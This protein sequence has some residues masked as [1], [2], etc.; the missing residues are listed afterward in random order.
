[1]RWLQARVRVRARARVRVKVGVRVRGRRA[2]VRVKAWIRVKVGVSGAGGAGAVQGLVRG[3]VRGLRHLSLVGVHAARDGRARDDE[4]A[5]RASAGHH[6]RIHLSAQLAACNVDRAAVVAHKCCGGAASCEAPPLRR[7]RACDAYSGDRERAARS[8]GC[9]ELVRVD[10]DHGPLAT[11]REGVELNRDVLGPDQDGLRDVVRLLGL[12]LKHLIRRVTR[13]D[14]RQ[15]FAARQVDVA[16]QQ[17]RPCGRASGRRRWLNL[18]RRG[19]RRDRVAAATRTAHLD[20]AEAGDVEGAAHVGLL[21][22]LGAA[23]GVTV[24]GAEVQVST[25]RRQWRRLRG[26]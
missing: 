5:G 18:R 22:V 12:E 9:E 17:R 10:H 16:G 2:R 21:H 6:Q 7:L 26:W 11:G 25:D 13:D 4:L 23:I 14:R 20:R 3:S 19:R 15:V 24:S 8:D 1:M